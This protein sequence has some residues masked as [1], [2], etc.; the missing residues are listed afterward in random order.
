M[1]KDSASQREK[2]AKRRLK[3][4]G[5]T[6]KPSVSGWS[7]SED[8]L[9]VGQEGNYAYIQVM[10]VKMVTLH[11]MFAMQLLRHSIHSIIL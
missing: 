5:K 8:E 10:H 11:I 3:Q 4:L 1:A 7:D 6:I 9:A 2:S